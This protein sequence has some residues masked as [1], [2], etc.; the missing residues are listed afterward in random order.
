M[1]K[2]IIK[3]K[4]F[5]IELP[6]IPAFRTPAKV[7]ISKL[8][9]GQ[10]I[11]G[12]KKQG[13]KDYEIIESLD[14]PPKKSKRKK[15]INKKETHSSDL[16][17]VHE[18]FDKIE[19]LLHEVITTRSEVREVRTIIKGSAEESGVVSEETENDEQF[20]PDVDTKGMKVRTSEFKTEKLDGNVEESSNL[21]S[22]MS[23]G[24]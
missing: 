22:K 15:P 24:K 9:I 23:R 20:V 7:D 8:N 11:T 12:L 14:K 10:V 13:I 18:R 16:S 21:L 6:K 19:K 5:F 1:I 2:L 3:K 17:G 4:G